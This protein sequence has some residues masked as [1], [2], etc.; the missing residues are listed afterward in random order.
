MSRVIQAA[1]AVGASIAALVGSATTAYADPS[2]D[3]YTSVRLQAEHSGKCLTIENARIGSGAHAVQ[4]PCAD[5][6]DNQIFKLRSRGP[7]TISVQAKHSGRCL[8]ADKISQDVTQLWCSDGSEQRWRVMLVEVA[9]DLY[10][11]RPL[12]APEY[13]LT[14][15]YFIDDNGASSQADG[16]RAGIYPCNGASNKRWRML[17]AAS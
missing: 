11:L 3:A 16:S 6:L 14:I 7:G 8:A 9:K 2:T 4:Q 5:D 12:D 15:P 10:E 1:L 17:P 13:C